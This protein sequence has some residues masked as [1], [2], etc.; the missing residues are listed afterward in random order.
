MASIKRITYRNHLNFIKTDDNNSTPVYGITKFSDLSPKEFKD[1]YLSKHIEQNFPKNDSWNVAKYMQVPV[2]ENVWDWR[3]KNVVTPVKDQGG[4]G[5]CW[6]FSTVENVET[7]WALSGNQVTELSTQEVVDCSNNNYGCKGGSPCNAL[8]WLKNNKIKLAKNNLYP[9]DGSTEKCRTN[10][11]S[12]GVGVLDYFCESCFGPCPMVEMKKMLPL[13]H[14]IGP[15]AV[16]VNAI[17]W[18]DYIGGVIQ[19]HCSFDSANHAVQ[20]VGY[21]LNVQPPYWIVRNSWGLNFG[22]EGYLRI[23][24]GDNVCGRKCVFKYIVS[25]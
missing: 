1:R 23:K 20:I 7:S 18:Q 12:D 19:H 22:E 9:Y 5:S 13:V 8:I 2:T 6:A 10:M 15:L 16:S 4:C 14:A 3:K 17:S 24:V 11:E 21:N 25:F